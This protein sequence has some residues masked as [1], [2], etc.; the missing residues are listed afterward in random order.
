LNWVDFTA[1][2]QAVSMEMALA[3]YGVMLRR[4]GGSYIRGRC[5]LPSH[6]SKSST[7][8]FIVN[9]EK[10]AWICHSDSCV[11]S[12]GGRSGGNVLDFIAAM[13]RCS[14]G[15]AALR[16]GDWFG[17]TPADAPRKEVLFCGRTVLHICADRH[18]R[19]QSAT[20]L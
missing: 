8:S 3:Y 6:R 15:D 11:A 5:P 2:K 1:V 4:V 10:N 19:L 14:I 12:R 16:L 20:G 9:T 18:G 13:E 7:L 17:V